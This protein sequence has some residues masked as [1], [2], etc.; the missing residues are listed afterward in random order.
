[1]PF[2]REKFQAARVPQL[3]FGAGTL[4]ELPTLLKSR[5]MDRIGI[6]TGASW[7][8]ESDHWHTLL[9]GFTDRGCVV[10]HRTNGGE[11]SPDRVDEIGADFR[12]DGVKAVLG[13]GGGSILDAA[14]AAAV[15]ARVEGSIREYLEGVGTR[16]PDG[17]TLPMVAVPTSAGTGSEATKNAVLSEVGPE[18]FKK[19]LR[20][21]N[22][23]P[24][25]A[26]IDPELAVSAGPE[27][28]AA[29]GLDAI[30]QL[31]EAYISTKASIFTDSQAE[32]GLRLAGASFPTAV[33]DGED[34]NGRGD[35]A[36]AA[37]MSGVCLANAG[38]GIVHGAASAAGAAT[39]IPHGVFCGNLLV[40]ALRRTVDRLSRLGE[41]SG[42]AARK[43][44]RAAALLRGEEPNASSPAEMED[45]ISRLEEFLAISPLSRL[46]AY[47][48]TE[49]RL[50][51]VAERSGLKNHPVE[52]SQRDVRD[53]LAERL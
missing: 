49:D 47:G 25:L 29:S 46:S 50:D 48:F 31:L 12:A 24:I 52:F 44:R 23:I 35:M 9:R 10:T 38:L 16:R 40:P 42:M 18:G 30:T 13:I 37:F 36:Y 51:V 17:R 26:L 34:L 5:G 7:F 28:T 43:L 39:G 27:V 45:L 8:P 3:V 11:P 14:K 53:M 20:H 32:T 6:V 1:M 41:T 4:S 2:M 19:S 21:D 33:Q 22:F 15:A